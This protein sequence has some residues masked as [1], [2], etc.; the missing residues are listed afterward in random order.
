MPP[1][2]NDTLVNILDA[3][4]SGIFFDRRFYGGV[5]HVVYL[6]C[7]PTVAFDRMKIRNRDAEKTV[8]LTYLNSLHKYH[9]NWLI[10]ADFLKMGQLLCFNLNF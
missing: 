2:C 7:D 9:D 4:D 5:H 10:P 1:I 3:V 6:R 8:P